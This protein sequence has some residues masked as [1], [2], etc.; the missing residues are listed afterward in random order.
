MEPEWTEADEL[1]IFARIDQQIKENEHNYHE[2]EG[3]FRE[4]YES[5]E[6]NIINNSIIEIMGSWIAELYFKLKVWIKR[7]R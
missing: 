3:A 2:R 7:W 1:R 5:W 6:D 4:T